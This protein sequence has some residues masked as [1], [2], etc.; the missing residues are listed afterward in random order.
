[1]RSHPRLRPVLAVLGAGIVAL[2]VAACGDDNKD[3]S[4]K[5]DKLQ[6]L[7]FTLGADGKLQGVPSAKSGLTQISF[8]NQAKKKYDL[9]LVRVE[10]NH[11][12]AEVLKVTS[13]DGPVPIPTFMKGGGGV[14]TTD[15]GKTATITQLLDGGRYFVL[16]EPDQG[17][18]PVTAEMTVS[19][20]KGTGTL[21][22]AD[23]KVTATEYKFDA[24][25]LKA[26]RQKIEFDNDG[27]Q[28]H[29]AI[30]IPIK[31]GVT[32]AQAK[33][34]FTTD[35]KG[36]GPPPFDAKRNGPSTTVIDSGVKLVFDAQ[37][38]PGKYALVCFLSDRKGGPPHVAKGMI[39]E[40]DVT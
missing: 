1:M 25:G 12:L 22:K 5:S 6:S 32:L 33:K 3:K 21:P 8:T 20:G 2:A 16:A 24:T 9:Q 34:F 13:S 4:G 17:G 7:D 26:G 29:H 38:D 28:L 27:A 39:S 40:V 30:F 14:G 31:A 37:L 10:G 36:A 15:A 23:A 19:G 11:T 35:G 18:K